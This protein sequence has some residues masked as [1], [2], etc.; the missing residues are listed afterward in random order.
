MTWGGQDT[1]IP[2]DF[3]GRNNSSQRSEENEPEDQAFLGF[4]SNEECP[5]YRPSRSALIGGR[6]GGAGQPSQAWM[7]ATS[8]LC[9]KFTGALG[10]FNSYLPIIYYRLHAVLGLEL[11]CLPL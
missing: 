5:E 6:W 11:K 10:L 7:R 4:L 9:S 2:Q 1:V 8:R 3:I